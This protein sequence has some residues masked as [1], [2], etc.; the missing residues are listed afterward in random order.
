MSEAKTI[1]G[2]GASLDE[3]LKNALAA[4]EAK[5]SAADKIIELTVTDWGFKGGGFAGTSSYWVKAQ[6]RAIG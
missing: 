6:Y 2:S 3:S 4:A 1:E 5:E